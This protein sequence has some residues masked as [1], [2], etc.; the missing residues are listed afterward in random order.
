MYFIDN[1]KP[2]TMIFLL[3]AVALFTRL[4]FIGRKS[5]WI[6]E[7]LAWGA[8]QMN[9]T[10]MFSSIASGTPHP[11]MAFILMKLSSMLAGGTEGGLR[12]LIAL[13]VASAVIP[14]FR[15]TSR[16]TTVIGGFWAG[17]MW[18]LSP[19]AVSI[20]QEAWVYGFNL[21][22]SLWF[23]DLADLAWRGSGKAF[24][25]SLILGVMGILTQHIFVLTIVV[26]CILYFTIPSDKRIRFKKFAVVPG[27]LAVLYVPLFFFFVPQFF[28]RSA[29]MASAGMVFSF[30]RLFGIQSISQFFRILAGGILPDMS[31]NLLDRPRMLSVYALNAG[32]VLFLTFWAYFTKILKPGDRKYLWFCLLVPFALFLTDTPT[33][34]QISILW[35]PFSITSA[36]VFS[37]YRWMGIVVSLLCLFAL[38]PYYRL[39]TFPYH[40]SDW[41][42]AIAVVESNA[43]PEDIVVVL[44][45]KSTSFA[46]LFYSNSDRSIAIAEEKTPEL[47]DFSPP[48]NLIKKFLIPIFNLLK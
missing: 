45:G 9:W 22:I 41:R 25:G 18:A 24:A 43:S 34:R 1:R 37:R 36:A 2:R 39:T 17:M 26:S 3:S 7:C 47:L 35:I 40:Q 31:L 8:T 38:I 21:A 48:V 23:V 46:W 32:F 33:I 14:V 28:Q 27:L 19:F 10:E 4:L 16:K 5:F 29:R 6:D 20:G 15:L 13:V 44:G 30:S 42:T 11:P 12:F